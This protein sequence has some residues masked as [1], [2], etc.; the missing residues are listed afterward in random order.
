[1][2]TPGHTA[3][4]LLLLLSSHCSGTALVLRTHRSEAVPLEE[5]ACC[6]VD[7]SCLKSLFLVV[8]P[9]ML[10]VQAADASAVAETEQ[11]GHVTDKAQG[12]CSA[13]TPVSSFMT[14]LNFTAE[15][16]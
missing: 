4:A 7:R 16:S 12:R 11:D 2:M 9:A 10:T 8:L 3:A 15:S 1:M 13:A 14:W 6:W 5:L